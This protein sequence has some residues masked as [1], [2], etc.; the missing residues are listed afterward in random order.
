MQREIQTRFDNDETAT[1]P[2]DSELDKSAQMNCNSYW[3]EKAMIEKLTR[4]T[5]AHLTLI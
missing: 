2:E 5:V 1:K 4:L 3:K